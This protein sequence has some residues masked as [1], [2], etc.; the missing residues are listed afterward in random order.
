MNSGNA[1]QNKAIIIDLE[2]RDISKSLYKAFLQAGI[3]PII[4]NS[5][6]I[7]VHVPLGASFFRD[8]QPIE[9]TYLNVEFAKAI[10]LASAGKPITFYETP[11]TSNRN[12]ENLFEKFGYTQLA[13]KYLQVQIL[14]LEEESLKPEDIVSLNYGFDY[15][16]V[17]L[18]RF[19]FNNKNLIISFSNPKAPF[20]E[21][22]AGFK[23]LPFSL[24]GK[25]LIIGSTLFHKKNL[26]HLA[27][28]DIGLGLKDYIVD[29][30]ERIHKAGVVC[31][32]INGGRFAGSMI[33]QVKVDPID[34]N[35][36]IVSTSIGI[37]DA[38]TASI[39]GFKPQNLEFF[40]N[41]AQKGLIPSN[42]STIPIIEIGNSRNRL[43]KQLKLNNPFLPKGTP[44]T[45][46]QWIFGMLKQVSFK[47]RLHLI[48]KIIPSIIKY[49]FTRKKKSNI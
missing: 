16:P 47:D 19:L 49:K 5:R 46:R 48:S 38:V 45:T 21:T 26:L 31:V 33:E 12:I 43:E 20:S 40:V 44:I 1:A 29:A 37:S 13:S 17:R 27:F 4:N 2:N 30:L 25:S 3:L 41:L 7:Y 18:P 35:S 8:E 28:S 6:E 42:T 23:G 11:A 22:V 39:M 10:I 15:P 32:G 14:C 24:S 9:G 34:W 36:L